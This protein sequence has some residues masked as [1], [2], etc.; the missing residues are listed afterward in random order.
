MRAN[1]ITSICRRS[2]TTSAPSLDHTQERPM[3]ITPGA[4]SCTSG[5]EL[6]TYQLTAHVQFEP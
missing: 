1:G 6:V 4:P 2:N 3:Q 5:Q